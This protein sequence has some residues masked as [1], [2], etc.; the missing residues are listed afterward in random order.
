MNENQTIKEIVINWHLTETCNYSCEYCFSKYNDIC[1]THEV[2]RSRESYT[3]LLQK[4][5]SYFSERYL[6]PVRLNLAGGEPLLSKNIV[7]IID[8]AKNIGFNVSIIT[9]G[10]LL[11]PEITNNLKNKLSTIGVSIDSDSNSKDIVI[12]RCT[13][14][15]KT[16][17]REN[18]IQQLKVLRD[19]GTVIKVN[20]VVC[21]YNNECDLNDLITSI[22]PD[23][24]K[25]LQ[26][27]PVNDIDLTVS[28]IE[29]NKFINKH[30][31]HREIMA[32]ENNE[33]MTNSYIMVD[34]LGRFF[35]NGAACTGYTYSQPILLNNSI[36][37]C[38]N[39]IDFNIIKFIS[40]Y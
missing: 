11:T 18:L 17:D 26:A 27:L 28:E 20:T 16:L 24:W 33:L 10:S 4:L 19:S 8:V 9:N 30:K 6:I 7:S 29:F 23:K 34:P 39:E 35:Q 1:E 22:T 5:Y 31:D 36:D 12:G 25:V 38:F 13:R 40:R 2:H 3:A 14:S 21:K 15:K 37:Q 32:I